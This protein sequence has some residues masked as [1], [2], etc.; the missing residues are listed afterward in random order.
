MMRVIV[1]GV[2]FYTTKKRIES[3]VGDD[4]SVNTA[5]QVAY[6][7]LKPR[8]LGLATSVTVYDGRLVARQY[9]VQ[10]NR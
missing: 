7:M 6:S 2:S 9:N 3:G 5:V 8:E 1:N 10:I 4:T